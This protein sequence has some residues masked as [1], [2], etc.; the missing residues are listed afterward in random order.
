MNAKANFQAGEDGDEG[1]DGMSFRHA[2]SALVHIHDDLYVDAARV[3]SVEALEYPKYLDPNTVQ[4][5]TGPQKQ[6]QVFI[7]W[8]IPKICDVELQSRNI[9]CA[10]MAEARKLAGEIQERVNRGRFPL[11]TAMRTGVDPGGKDYSAVF[12]GEGFVAEAK[13]QCTCVY[14]NHYA[15]AEAK[16]NGIHHPGCPA[17]KA[18]SEM[19]KKLHAMRPDLWD[20]NGR[21]IPAQQIIAAQV[22]AARSEP[23]KTI[24]RDL[25]LDRVDEKLI[26]IL[27]AK[28]QEE[29]DAANKLDL[30][31]N[32]ADITRQII[33]PAM[34]GEFVQ[35]SKAL[36]DY[37]RLVLERFTLL[38]ANGGNQYAEEALAIHNQLAAIWLALT[39]E[40]RHEATVY[41]LSLQERKDGRSG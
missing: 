40:E 19:G 31:D 14:T 25:R 30:D 5:M 29:L 22:S 34:M 3:V 9:R 12:I 39:A 6:P 10:D 26:A 36:V 8:Q 2:P 28:T 23:W 1:V 20:E 27:Q 17:R 21:A 32:F 15:M 16:A 11:A 33:A 41:G 7:I 35:G 24:E 37:E 18:S 38:E 4:A 13:P